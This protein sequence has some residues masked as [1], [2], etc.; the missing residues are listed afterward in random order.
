MSNEK[1][2]KNEK[3]APSKV[4]FPVG[5][6][7]IRF[8]LENTD[9]PL[10]IMGSLELAG[11]E[12]KG[13]KIKFADNNHFAHIRNGTFTVN[14]ASFIA[15]DGYIQFQILGAAELYNPD[16]PP[17]YQFNFEGYY[18]YDADMKVWELHGTG[19][20]PYGFYPRPEL[21]AADGDNVTWTSKGITDPPHKHS[22]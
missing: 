2:E 22:K 12:T 19:Q 14:V 11:L 9:D 4:D 20:V 8:T 17:E 10:T 15:E 18:T 5:S 6:W 13:N 16:T 7:T 21:P 1:K 3:T